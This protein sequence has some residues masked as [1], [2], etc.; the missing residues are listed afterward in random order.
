MWRKQVIF[1]L[2]AGSL[3][4]GAW[5]G[6]SLLL[7]AMQGEEGESQSSA[8]TDQPPSPLIDPN[9]TPLP[10]ITEDP[11]LMAALDME[12][13][14]TDLAAIEGVAAVR[15]VDIQAFQGT[16]LAFLEI[17]TLEGYQSESTAAAIWTALKAYI[18]EDSQFSVILWD[19][20]QRATNYTWDQESQTWLSSIVVSD[21]G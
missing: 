10:A 3:F 21:P 9:L 13:I 8:P 15:V 2:A 18:S 4:V 16:W 11:S 20:I 7:I 14:Q 19:R 6:L 5:I 1:G 17:D 12:A